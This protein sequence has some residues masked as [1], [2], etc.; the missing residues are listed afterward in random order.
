MRFSS[1]NCFFHFW[2]NRKDANHISSV[3][4][5]LGAE[6]RCGI[7]F[8]NKGVAKVNTGSLAIMNNA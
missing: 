6:L 4:I 2:F 8:W 1:T 7:I 5:Y 3:G